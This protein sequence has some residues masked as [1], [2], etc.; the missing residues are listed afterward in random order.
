MT[1]ARCTCFQALHNDRC[2]GTARLGWIADQAGDF[3]VLREQGRRPAEQPP[4]I[5]TKLRDRFMFGRSSG[6]SIGHLRCGFSLM[7]RDVRLDGRT[8]EINGQ[9]GMSDRAIPD[10]P[11][12]TFADS[13]AGT[14]HRAN[15]T[16]TR[17]LRRKP[18]AESSPVRDN[19]AHGGAAR[20]RVCNIP[21]VLSPC[22]RTESRL[23]TSINTRTP[24]GRSAKVFSKASSTQLLRRPTVISGSARNSAC[25]ASTAFGPSR[26]SRRRAS[27]SP[28]AIFEAC[29]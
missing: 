7:A 26:G 11:E 16:I 25:F 10:R 3:G 5:K 6:H 21:D 28:A 18:P 20:Y 1:V 29:S 8:W 22:V 14:I 24:R 12:P 27:I 23:S 13:G 2:A 19:N 4:T 17:I 9:R 15:R